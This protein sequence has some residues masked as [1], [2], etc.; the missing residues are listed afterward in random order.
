MKV[1][2]E[3]GRRK[4]KKA[5][6]SVSNAPRCG[7]KVRIAGLEFAKRNLE[8]RGHARLQFQNLSQ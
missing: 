1:V 4:E 6:R 2:G 3:N 7:V 5:L 8:G